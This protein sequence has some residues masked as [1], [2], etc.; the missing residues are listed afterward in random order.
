MATRF[1][2]KFVDDKSAWIHMDLSAAE[3][4]GGLAHIPTEHTG[5]K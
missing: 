3:P 4:K 5:F 2:N 1:L